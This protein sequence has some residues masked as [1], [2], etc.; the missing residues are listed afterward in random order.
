[1][2]KR[3]ILAIV[4]TL[5]YWTP[6]SIVLYNIIEGDGMLFPIWIDTLLLPSYFLGFVLGFSSGNI[7][8][9]IGQIITL[10]LLFLIINGL[11]RSVQKNK[12]KK[13]SR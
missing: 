2:N 9:I 7:A 8:A 4:V 1:M 11:F 6:A 10:I 5:S 12:I 13:N 3:V